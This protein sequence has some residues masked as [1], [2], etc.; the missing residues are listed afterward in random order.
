M[1]LQKGGMVEPRIGSTGSGMWEWETR[2]TGA[3]RSFVTGIL[4]MH[5]AVR[6]AGP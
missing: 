4:R 2:E 1:W 6:V 5:V 3:T